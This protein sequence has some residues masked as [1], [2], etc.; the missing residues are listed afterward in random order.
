MTDSHD[1][2]NVLL[3]FPALHTKLT[4]DK[5]DPIMNVHIFLTNKQAFFFQLLEMENHFKVAQSS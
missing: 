4:A 2:M 1:L 5:I 3:N